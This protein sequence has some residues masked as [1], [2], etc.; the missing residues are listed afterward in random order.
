[1][2]AG[3]LLARGLSVQDFASYSYL[4]LTM[5]MIAAYA[6]LGLG[7]IA[8]RSFSGLVLRRRKSLEEIAAIW[9]LSLLL[10]V[11]AGIILLAGAADF[12]PASDKVSPLLVSAVLLVSLLGIIPA[13]AIQGLAAFRGSA[14]SAA[15]GF[16]LLLALAFEASRQGSLPL[17][18][19][20]LLLA[21]SCI[22]FGE[23]YL[24]FRAVGTEVFRIDRRATAAGLRRVLGPVTSTALVSV[25]SGTA[26]WMVATMLSW[27][28]GDHAVALF[29]IGL[30]WFAL[31]LFL[32]GILTRVAFAE[33]AKLALEETEAGAGQRFLMQAVKR[34]LMVAGLLAAM[35]V[36]AAPWL[37]QLYGPNFAADYPVTWGFAL[38]GAATSATNLVGNGLIVLGRTRTWLILTLVWFVLL[39]ICTPL[40]IPSMGATGAGLAYFAA[41]L[42]LL[43]VALLAYRRGQPNG[44]AG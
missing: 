11:M 24:A 30:Q 29:S 19:T 8:S 12:L 27:R 36:A 9:G 35:A 40:I 10:A 42:A 31:V 18:V 6:S 3:I 28:S 23:G 15:V 17:A 32:P 43:S 26:A 1:M 39:G 4:I 41:N 21:Q 38:A 16:V 25:L 37:M 22:S 5:N 2:L 33:Q 14:F 34:N 44:R 7:A 20:G 13:A